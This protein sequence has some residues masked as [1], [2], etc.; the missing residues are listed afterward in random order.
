MDLVPGELRLRQLARNQHR[1]PTPVHLLGM[2]VRLVEREDQDLLQHLDHVVVGVVVVVQQHYPVERNQALLLDDFSFGRNRGLRHAVRPVCDIARRA[3]SLP[4]ARISGLRIVHNGGLGSQR[5]PV[6]FD[7]HA[8]TPVDP[9]VLEA[10]LPYFGARFG[11]AASRSHAFGWEAEKAVELARK[12][13]AA[14]AGA[15]PR[16]IVFTSGATESNNLAIKGVMEA[17]RSKGNHLVT[18]ATEHPSVLDTVRHLERQGCALAILP[19]EPDGLLSL[20]RLR[21][22]IRPDTVL[23]SVMYANN[24]IGV[25]QPV[26]EIGAICHEMGA[27]YHCDAAQAFG[28]LPL[29][30][31]RDH[32]DLISVTAH[33]IYGPK[34]AGAL[35]VRRRNPRVEVAA[36]LD[37]GGHESGR[38]SGTLNVPG[39]VGFGEACRICAEEMAVEARRIGA[40]RDRLWLLLGSA[41]DRVSV[42]G[43]MAHRL[44]GNLHL[45]FAGV[46]GDALLTSLPDIAV[47]AASA[48]S[49]ARVEASHVLS[50]IGA[51]EGAALRFGLGRFNTQEEVDYVAARVIEAVRQLRALAPA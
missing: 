22:A 45:T 44:P 11:N 29:D 48:C 36:Q 24:E 25:I 46:D 43:S 1:P 42:N 13:V 37:G 2:P 15:E 31:D 26:R 4:A 47:S 8:T 50:A 7:H 5:Q 6:Y 16:E 10:M 3:T 21:R 20:D 51:P 39:I 38:R 33:K 23:V 18:M 41:L 12:R 49:S 28:K 32:I 40:L 14:L 19:P 17:Y 35:Y 34:G 30:V 9:R 27:L